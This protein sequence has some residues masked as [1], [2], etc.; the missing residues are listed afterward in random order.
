MGSCIAKMSAFLAFLFFRMLISHLKSDVIFSCACCGYYGD[1]V[2]EDF[3]NRR[4]GGEDV[5]VFLQFVYIS[6]VFMFYIWFFG[7]HFIV[8]LSS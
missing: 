6:F 8:D 4:L 3:F 2:F 1:Q 7:M 5:K